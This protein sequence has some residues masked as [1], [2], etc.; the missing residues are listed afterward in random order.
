ME[1]ALGEEVGFAQHS[2][3]VTANRQILRVI[4]SCRGPAEACLQGLM[5]TTNAEYSVGKRFCT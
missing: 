5:P 3:S 1:V 4:L 2:P